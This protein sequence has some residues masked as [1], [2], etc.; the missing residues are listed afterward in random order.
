MSQTQSIASSPTILTS[1]STRRWPFVFAFLL[2]LL[3]LPVLGLPAFSDDDNDDDTLFCR[4]S[5]KAARVPSVCGPP[6]PL[7]IDSEREDTVGVDLG[8]RNHDVVIAVK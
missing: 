8:S 3:P 2:L 7:T 4:Q 6:P 5:F 1:V